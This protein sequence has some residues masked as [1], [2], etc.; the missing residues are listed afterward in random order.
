MSRGDDNQVRESNRANHKKTDK[1][2]NF[3]KDVNINTLSVRTQP[4]ANRLGLTNSFRNGFLNSRPVHEGGQ[5]LILQFG[6]ARRS[7]LTPSSVT[8]VPSRCSLW[9]LL[10][11]LKFSS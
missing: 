4:N 10:S 9:S 1:N 8:P 11:P 7:F 2:R 3:Q 5:R 6:N